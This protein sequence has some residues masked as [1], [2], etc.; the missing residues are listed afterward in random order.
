MKHLNVRIRLMFNRAIVS[1]EERLFN[2]LTNFLKLMA[3]IIFNIN[4]V[5]NSSMN[6]NQYYK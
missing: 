6:I 2:Q 1:F 4:L 5:L 3:S